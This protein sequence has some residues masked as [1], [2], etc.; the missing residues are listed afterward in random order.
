MNVP[1]FITDQRRLFWVLQIGGWAAWGLIGKYGYNRVLVGEISPN[2]LAYVAVITVIGIVITL[3]LRLV[4]QYVW[5]KP[6]W[7][8]AVAFAAGSAAAGWLWIQARSY[9]YTGWFEPRKDTGEWLEKMGDAAELYE[10]VYFL[11]YFMGSLSVM[12]A[13]SALYFGV[14]YARLFREMRESALKRIAPWATG[15]GKPRALASA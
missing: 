15:R 1:I 3:G 12:M 10:R 11:D 5:T 14:K 4:Y 2:Y 9:I 13:W 6:V 8:R 7:A